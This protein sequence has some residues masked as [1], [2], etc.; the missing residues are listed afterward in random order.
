MPSISKYY[1]AQKREETIQMK[2]LSEKNLCLP[3]KDLLNQRYKRAFDIIS[4]YVDKNSPLLDVGCRAGHC[5]AY[6]KNNGFLDVHGVDI[7]ERG[8]KCVNNHGMKG[9]K[10]DAHE[11]NNLLNAEYYGTVLMLHSLEHC[12]NPIKVLC[13]VS[14]LMISGGFLF[15]EVPGRFNDIPV[16]RIEILKGKVVE[17]PFSKKELQEL[18]TKLTKLF[19]VSS[20][21]PVYRTKGKLRDVQWNV[22]LRKL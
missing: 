22:L 13:G 19:V 16:K 10:L 2:R 20:F 7:S 4:S 1:D 8:I 21:N 17:Y 9:Y 12:Y 3:K 18:F 5:M 11:M 15:I 14:K 6:F